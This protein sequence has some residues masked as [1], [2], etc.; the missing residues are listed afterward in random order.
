M[1]EPKLETVVQRLVYAED[2]TR[3]R[4]REARVH[5]VPGAESDSCLIFDAGHICRRL[6]V[7]P[8]QWSEMSDITIL[9][10]MDKPR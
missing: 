5:D 8:D 4:V 1:D 9:A 10:I 6:W 3:W 7:F 2:G